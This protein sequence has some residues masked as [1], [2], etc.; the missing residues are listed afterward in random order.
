MNRRIVNRTAGPCKLCGQDVPAGTG[1]AVGVPTGER[2]RARG[3][4]S[5]VLAWHVEHTAPRWL[6]SPVSG[7]WAGGCPAKPATASE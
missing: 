4:W 7:R 2:R 3:Q 6:G 1:E 5:H